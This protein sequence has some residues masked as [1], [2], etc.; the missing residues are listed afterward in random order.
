MHV[1]K[2]FG[3]IR[4]SDGC[5]DAFFH[6]RDLRDG[7]AFDERLIERRVQFNIIDGRGGKPRAIDIRAAR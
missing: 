5:G 1:D 2:G 7:L 6:H 3:F 4:L